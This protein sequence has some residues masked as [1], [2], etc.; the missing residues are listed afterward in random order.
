LIRDNDSSKE[1]LK[2]YFTDYPNQC[3]LIYS[4]WKGYLS[5]PRYSFLNSY[6]HEYLHT[7]G[8]ADI[9]SIKEVVK[10]VKP[11]FIMP[12]HTEHPEEFQNH[13]SNVKFSKLDL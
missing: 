1:K 12:I 2:K 8:H 9:D 4:M 10:T 3:L 11:K 13:F 5:E 6:K 7:S